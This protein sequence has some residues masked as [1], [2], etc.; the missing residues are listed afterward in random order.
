MQKEK[1]NTLNFNQQA[2][3]DSLYQEY[4]ELSEVKVQ[5]FINNCNFDNGELDLFESEEEIKEALES[6]VW[7]NTPEI[8]CS[9]ERKVYHEVTHTMHHHKEHFFCLD[10]QKT[11]DIE[12]LIEECNCDVDMS[13]NHPNTSGKA[14]AK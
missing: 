2:E 11:V 3:I 4:K 6:K 9:H 14:A 12:K 10:C 13:P 8:E 7:L 1:Y 5:D